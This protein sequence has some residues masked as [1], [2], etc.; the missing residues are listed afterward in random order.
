MKRFKH[1]IIEKEVTVSGA[2]SRGEEMEEFIVAALNG[3]P[4]PISR[5]GIEPGAGEKVVEQLPFKPKT[6]QVT[7]LGAD[8]IDVTAKWASFWDPEKVPSSTKTPKTDLKASSDKVSLKTGSDAQLMSGGRNESVATFYAAVELSGTS[9]DEYGKKVEQA[10]QDLSPSR[11]AAGKLAAEIKKG[12][13]QLVVAADKAHKIL[14]KD[15]TNM[16]EGNPKFAYHFIREAMTGETKFGG[17]DG[18]CTHFLTCD[19]NGENVHYIPVTDEAYVRKIANRAKVSVRMKST[20]EKKKVGGKSTKTG[21]YRYWSAV[22]ILADKLTEEA[23]ALERDGVLITENVVSRLLSKFV[24]FLKKMVSKIVEHV[25]KGAKFA[26][27]FM[28][29]EPQIEFVNSVDFR[30]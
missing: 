18:T 1:H 27:E 9:L 5:F 20:S 14:T 15:L 13:D 11:M 3:E 23:E 2:R 28:G 30:P 6:G 26:L 17:N 10:F 25:K 24:A 22:G 21:R 4:E 19:F 8:Q 29:L 16:F 7:V 12:T